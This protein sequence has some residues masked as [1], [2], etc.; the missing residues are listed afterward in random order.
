[1]GIYSNNKIKQRYKESTTELNEKLKKIYLSKINSISS[2]KMGEKEFFN[3]LK[4]IQENALEEAAEK[5]TQ[6]LQTTDI[7]MLDIV[8]STGI[9]KDVSNLQNIFNKFKDILEQITGGTFS[10]N[11]IPILTKDMLNG[12]VSVDNIKKVYRDA[13]LSDRFTFKVDSTYTRAISSHANEINKMLA[14]MSAL[15]N[16]KNGGMNSFSLETQN[17]T[18]NAFI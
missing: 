16:I 3:L 15:E 2:N 12:D 11:P 4:N 8:K 6:K 10:K 7:S 18:I 17:K 9:E 5:M 1:M 14:S 13:Y